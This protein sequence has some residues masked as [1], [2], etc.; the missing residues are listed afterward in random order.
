M[1]SGPTCQCAAWIR[2]GSSYPAAAQAAQVSAAALSEAAAPTPSQTGA[3]SPPD[4]CQ[5]AAS[6]QKCP[7]QA[8]FTMDAGA[9]AATIIA[10]HCQPRHPLARSRELAQAHY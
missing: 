8:R 9:T 6:R 2:L 7:R 1:L 4:H 3:L 10:L 5:A